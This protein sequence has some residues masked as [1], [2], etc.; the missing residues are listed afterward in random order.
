MT[1]SPSPLN[2]RVNV[3]APEP[4]LIANIAG[5]IGVLLQAP[6]H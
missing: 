4:R 3:I 6:H 5:I 2:S 1:R